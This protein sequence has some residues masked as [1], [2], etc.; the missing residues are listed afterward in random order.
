MKIKLIIRPSFPWKRESSVLPIFWIPAGVHPD[1]NRGRDDRK[2]KS[3][4]GLTFMMNS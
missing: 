1:E 4:I 3:F 2:R